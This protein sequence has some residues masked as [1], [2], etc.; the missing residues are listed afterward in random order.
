MRHIP[1]LLAC[2]CV[3]IF[4]HLAPAEEP[5]IIEP[6]PEQLKE[7]TETLAKAGVGYYPDGGLDPRLKVDRPPRYLGQPIPVFEPYVNWDVTKVPNVPF[8]FALNLRRLSPGYDPRYQRL[9]DLS[10]LTNLVALDLAGPRIS[11]QELEALKDL[12]QIRCL[13]LS[14]TDVTDQRI[15]AIA[16]L[17]NLEVLDLNFT[18]VTD[19]GVKDLKQLKKLAVLGLSYNITDKG[20]NDVKELKELTSLGLTGTKITDEGVAHLAELKKLK[21]LTL[22]QTKI[23]DAGI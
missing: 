17:T 14:S 16:Q 1:C 8:S 2:L 12:K 13:V 3:G 21:I 20:L 10:R 5:K 7:A 18:K 9:K 19:E 11:D 22:R 4:A 15:K 6:T 23:T